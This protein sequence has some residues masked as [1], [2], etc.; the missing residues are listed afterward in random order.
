[1]DKT[2]GTC[3][4]C[5]N[6]HDGP[7][8]Y[9]GSSPRPI[10]PLRV[11]DCWV[12]PSEAEKAPVMTKVCSHC[13]RELPVSN[14]G[15]HS[16]TKDGYQPCCKECLSEMNKGHKKRQPFEN[17][18]A[19]AKP[20]EPEVI[21]EGMKRCYH[22]KQILPVSEFNKAAGAKDGLQSVCR[23]CISELNKE[24]SKT[25]TR[26]RKDPSERKTPGPKAAHPAYVNEATGVTMRWCCHC[27]QYKPE[28]E[29]YKDRSNKTGFATSCKACG[30]IKE[31]ERR[32]K[33]REARK[34]EIQVQATPG[35]LLEQAVDAQKEKKDEVMTL[36][37]DPSK[38]RYIDPRDL[39]RF[40][41]LQ[42]VHE[43]RRRGFHGSITIDI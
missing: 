18:E 32:R 39:Q 22:C 14:F 3:G 35:G 29:F 42:I 40:D 12:D 38:I 16:R 9:K 31:K 20:E 30:A 7:Y 5:R 6:T 24:Y 27:K 4:K 19:P 34:A 15:R 41:I 17:N 10:S 23:S 11:M 43:L 8:C 36:Q 28:S 21:P 37:I 33:K 25:R 26:R 1:M 2:C 13:G